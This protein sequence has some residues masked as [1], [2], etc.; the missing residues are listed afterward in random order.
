[1]EPALK[2]ENKTVVTLAADIASLQ[3]DAQELSDALS[4]IHAQIAEKEA[5]IRAELGYPQKDVPAGDLRVDWTPPNRRFDE[6]AFQMKYPAKTNA[7]MYKTVPAKTVIAKEMI[8]P[9]LKNDF[10]VPGHGE[11]KVTIR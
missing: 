6:E 4:Q 1:M 9:A 11:G 2:T 8:P 3:G 7:H 5:L 10:M